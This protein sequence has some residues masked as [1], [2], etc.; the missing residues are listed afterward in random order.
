MFSRWLGY[1]GLLLF[2]VLICLLVLFG[3]IRNSRGTLIGYVVSKKAAR[4]LTNGSCALAA[5]ECLVCLSFRVC[6]LGVLTLIIS[7]GSLGLELAV[8]AV[9]VATATCPGL[10]VSAVT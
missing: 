3:L 9:S 2:D 5:E 6:L 1:L 8:A 7:W 10:P 4:C